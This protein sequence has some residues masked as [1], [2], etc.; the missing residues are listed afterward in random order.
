MNTGALLAGPTVLSYYQALGDLPQ[1]REQ[2]ATQ[3]WTHWADAALA[4]LGAPHPDLARRATRVDITRYGHAMSIPLPGIQ[5]F[6]SQI[7]LQRLSGKRKQLSNGERTAWI[8]TSA[9]ARLAFAHSDWSGYS[10]FEEAF[11][12]GHG[13]G[14]VAAG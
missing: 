1:A 2:L 11:T 13:A 10:M 14:L 7:G 5:A 12:R 3:P 4:T 9:T 8:P 6:L